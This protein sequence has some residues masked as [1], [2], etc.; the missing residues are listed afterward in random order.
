MN[1]VGGAAGGDA[2]RISPPV[3]APGRPFAH[4]GGMKNRRQIIFEIEGH[5]IDKW[6]TI[7]ACQARWKRAPL[8]LA[9]DTLR[10]R[11]DEVP[12]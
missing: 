9:A 4:N 2:S 5:A 8:K 6:D 3:I 7:P 1:L 10:R 12:P 11:V